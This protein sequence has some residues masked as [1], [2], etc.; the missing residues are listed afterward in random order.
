MSEFMSIDMIKAGIENLD[1]SRENV[2]VHLEPSVKFVKNNCRKLLDLGFSY[3]QLAAYCAKKA[4]SETPLQNGTTTPH[5]NSTRTTTTPTVVPPVA[6]TS[7]AR[8]LPANLPDLPFFCFGQMK[9]VIHDDWVY[10]N[11]G[12]VPVMKNSD[13]RIDPESGRPLFTMSDGTYS[14][15]P[16][17]GQDIKTILKDT[18][19]I[20]KKQ[21]EES[22]ENRKRTLDQITP[23]DPT[24]APAPAPAPIQD[25]TPPSPDQPQ[26]PPRMSDRVYI[27]L[28]K[29]R[30]TSHMT[31]AQKRRAIELYKEWEEAFDQV[32]SDDP[33]QHFTTWLPKTLP[34]CRSNRIAIFHEI[35]YRFQVDESEV[36]RL[37]HLN[38][39]RFAVSTYINTAG[40]F[41]DDYVQP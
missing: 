37:H 21:E 24:P 32:S 28:L 10:R 14:L 22:K 36:L 30:D 23:T 31:P 15:C 41:G 33:V 3:K 18:V 34:R 35:A 39:M 17:F 4:P 27:N 26:V 29:R 9:Y 8:V 38:E 16:G 40:I 25:P 13:F 20:A 19:I 7:P 1:C 12:Y 11:G 6:S 2:L 5:S